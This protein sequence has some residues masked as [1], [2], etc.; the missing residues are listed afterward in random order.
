MKKE[1]CNYSVVIL[2]DTY[3]IVSDESEDHVMNAANYVHILM[4]DYVKKMPHVP[5]KTLAVFT[6]LQLAS[7]VLKHEA[8]LHEQA[9][10]HDSLLSFIDGS[11]KR[12]SAQV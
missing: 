12:D 1:I 6:S 7:L 9:S 8:V 5:L 11:I 2:D 3:T 10:K 4:Q